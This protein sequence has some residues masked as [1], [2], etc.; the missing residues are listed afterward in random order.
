MSISS[1]I[2]DDS[3]GFEEEINRELAESKQVNN[4]SDLF[5][6][7]GLSGTIPPKRKV[8][9]YL[10]GATGWVYACVNAIADE[11]AMIDL[12]LYRVKGNE[13]EQVLRHPI[14]DVLYRANEFMTKFDMFWLTSQYMELSGEAPWFI[15][16]KGATPEKIILLRPDRLEIIPGKS[17]NII[18]GYYYSTDLKQKIRLEINEV[19]FLRNPDPDTPFRGKGTLSAAA[20][21]ADIDEYSDDWNRKFFYNS[22]R[23]DA[24]LQTQQKLTKD[25]LLMIEK[26]FKNKFQGLDNAHKMVVLQGGLE[27][28]PM[29]LSQKDM[30]FLEQ[31]KFSRDKILGIFRVPRTA[32]GITDDVNR[33]NAEAT[34]FVFAKRKIKPVMQRLVEQLNE[35]FVPLFPNSEGLY[36]DYDSPVPEDVTSKMTLYTNGLQNGWLSINEV[37]AMQG[38]DD[39]GE[40]GDKL[41]LPI[42]FVPIDSDPFGTADTV[43]NHVSMNSIRARDKEKIKVR[44]IKKA[45][46]DQVEKIVFG[47]LTRNKIKKAK[48]GADIPVEEKPMLVFQT[49]QLAVGDAFVPIYKKRMDRIFNSQRKRILDDLPTKGKALDPKKYKLDPED[50]ADLFASLLDGITLEIITEQS[51]LAYRFI[52]LSDKLTI[53]NNAVKNYI[54]NQVK[55]VIKD[56]TKETNQKLANALSTGLG[57]EESIPQIRKRVNELFTDMKVYR[58]ERIAR[59]ETL[60]ASNFAA[61]ETY[62]ESGVVKKKRWL[63]ALDDRT[64]E[65]CGPMNGKIIGLDDTFFDKGD[66]FR[67]R[68]GGELDLSYDDTDFPPLHVNCRCTVIPIIQRSYSI[69]EVGTMQKRLK[70][71]EEK[72]ERQDQ[73][74]AE[75][76][77]IKETLDKLNND[78]GGTN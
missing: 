25:Q 71:L 19:V 49:Q 32:L 41:R 15:T 73:E 69:E 44:E 43:E 47:M 9:D 37:R 4:L 3:N 78:N 34:D 33:A 42:N 27:Y 68:E 18:D 58:S 29:N 24:V 5:A 77:E 61:Q 76:A 13:V 55:K 38:L 40:E 11:V 21:S 8:S 31:Q 36:L 20:K 35:F 39:I 65:W 52:G 59:T 75:I 22:A 54:K 7:Y 67:G 63:T 23:P 2:A 26:K 28:K 51:E 56:A 50:E 74:I 16:Y 6:D 60:R 66:T 46:G 45:I 72:T 30:D 64:C 17:G 48:K 70:E 12:K 53:A 57:E 1:K 14:L 10:R 62:K